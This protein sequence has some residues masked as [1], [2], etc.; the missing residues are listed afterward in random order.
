MSEASGSERSLAWLPREV[1][2]EVEGKILQAASMGYQKGIAAGRAQTAASRSDADRREMEALRRELEDLR[3]ERASVAGGAFHDAASTF[4]KHST[5][6]HPAVDHLRPPMMHGVMN[7]IFGDDDDDDDDG[8]GRGGAGVDTHSRAPSTPSGGHS[9]ADTAFRPAGDERDAIRPAHLPKDAGVMPEEVSLARHSGASAAPTAAMWALSVS[10]KAGV[11]PE[12]AR[13]DLDLIS[14]RCQLWFAHDKL[15]RARCS[16]ALARWRLACQDRRFARAAAAA[17]VRRRETRAARKCFRAWAATGGVGDGAAGVGGGSAFGDASGFVRAAPAAGPAMNRK[18]AESLHAELTASR[19]ENE[20][21]AAALA[22]LREEMESRGPTP[23]ETAQAEKFRIHLQ[24]LQRDL[25]SAR[26]ERDAVRAAAGRA[27]REEEE[28]REA[29]RMGQR[30][31]GTQVGGSGELAVAAEDT[32]GVLQFELQSQ[33]A[34]FHAEFDRQ[35]RIAEEAT[36]RLRNEAAL[37]TRM[38][39]AHRREIARLREMHASELAGVRGDL[40]LRARMASSRDDRDGGRSP[41]ALEGRAGGTGDAAGA[42]GAGTGDSREPASRS[43]DRPGVPTA[44]AIAELERNEGR[45]RPSERVDAKVRGWNVPDAIGIDP[46][47]EGDEWDATRPPGRDTPD[48]E[49]GT[50]QSQWQGTRRKYAPSETGSER[51]GRSRA[52]TAAQIAAALRGGGGA[53]AVDALLRSGDFD[54]VDGAHGRSFPDG[55][56]FPGQG[57]V[58]RPSKSSRTMTVA[59]LVV[60]GFTRVEA[61]EALD[62]LGDDVDVDTAHEW[63]TDRDLTGGLAT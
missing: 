58:P 43:H 17:C 1:R 19:T 61:A 11:I 2:G 12:S 24:R 46:S 26:K 5:P 39:D 30:S 54:P 36:E 38:E 33:A 31:Q 23:R 62:A 27:E 55:R 42:S 34:K 56:S 9:V 44:R 14:S 48:A 59:Q 18:T 60:R 25:E 37:R 40:A 16:A 29:R 35:A 50:Q 45:M 21:L 10:A 6:T 28:A 3:S 8:A 52:G 15:K 13:E 7:P 20:R 47:G 57:T 41:A 53:T 49:T 63:L 4:S 51:S 32:A 22:R